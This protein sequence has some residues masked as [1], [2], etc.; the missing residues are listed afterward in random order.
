MASTG[1][2]PKNENNKVI[3]L[4]VGG[5]RYEVSRLLIEMYPDTMLARLISD[6]WSGEDD[7]E[8]FID[9]DGPRF[10]YVLDYMRDQKTT[11][12]MNINKESVL[13][14][15]EYFG[16]A[17]IP[18]ESIDQKL[19]NTLAQG[20]IEATQIDFA[21]R[22]KRMQKD[23]MLNKIA[24]MVY[25]AQFC[26]KTCRRPNAP[27]ILTL[28]EKNLKEIDFASSLI[29]RDG[30]PTKSVL[31]EI[32]SEYE[33]HVLSIGTSNMGRTINIT[34]QFGTTD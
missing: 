18:S 1:D 23:W 12:A 5:T 17:N 27:I 15:L 2:S 19:S 29:R 25:D 26:S 10:Q 28:C 4:N 14:E 33:L 30:E 6:E 9:R 16:F 3:R 11:L 32:L 24:S 20:H 8:V 21:K 31:M 13:T 22:V 34:F 7:Q